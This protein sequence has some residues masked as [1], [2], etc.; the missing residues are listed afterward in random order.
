MNTTRRARLLVID[1]D[2]TLLTTDYQLTALTV[3]RS[4]AEANRPLLIRFVKDMVL[5]M[6][7]VYETRSR[8]SIS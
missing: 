2:G 8:R 4:W 1:V 3:R 6:R 7:W 5:A